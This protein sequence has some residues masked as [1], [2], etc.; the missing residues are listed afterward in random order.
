MI[1]FSYLMCLVGITESF[2][3]L[4]TNIRSL[5]LNTIPIRDPFDKNRF[6]R[7]PISRPY[8]LSLIHI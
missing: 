7:Y 3:R 6:R 5:E 1:F 4:G 2:K 8:Y